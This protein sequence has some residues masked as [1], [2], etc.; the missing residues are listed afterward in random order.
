M[1]KDTIYHYCSLDTLINIFKNKT[2]RLSDVNRLNDKL[3]TKALMGLVKQRII[4]K[5]LKVVQGKYLIYGMPNDSAVKYIVETAINQLQLKNNSML[6]VTCF[7][8][9]EDL[10]SQWINYGDNGKGVAIGFNFD[11]FNFISNQYDELQFNKVHY[12]DKGID[13]LVLEKYSTLIFEQ[14]YDAMK[15]D[16]LY[17]ILTNPNG[18]NLLDKLNRESIFEE[19]IFDKHNS[20]KAENEYRLVFNPQKTKENYF[21]EI[22]KNELKEL[23][24]NNI[25]FKSIGNNIISYLD[26]HIDEFSKKGDELLNKIILGPN[27][28]ASEGDVVLLLKFCGFSEIADSIDIDP[29][30]SSYK[31]V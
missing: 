22:D 16:C 12:A 6:Y 11:Y 19:F 24:S 1:L 2:L 20:F 4:E 30:A 18:R 25:Q 9:E 13:D 21:E 26:L 17:G 7:S 3:E 28:N 14:I 10:L 15:D 29:S 8:G 27:C 23:F 5:M 31:I